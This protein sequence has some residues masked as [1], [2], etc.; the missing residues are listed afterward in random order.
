LAEPPAL[1]EPFAIHCVPVKGQI[2][3][4]RFLRDPDE[5]DEI[6]PAYLVRAPYSIWKGLIQRTVDPVQAVMK[7]QLFFEGDLQQLME[8]MPYRP[9]VDRILAELK[10][11]FVDE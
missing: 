9:I 5:L 7:R 10:T 6:E 2:T 8:R 11:E 1:R 3:R 4:L